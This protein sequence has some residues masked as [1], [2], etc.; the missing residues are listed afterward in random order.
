[1]PNNRALQIIYNM[2]KTK[3]IPKMDEND[4]KRFWSKVIVPENKNECW[5][6]QAS[7]DSCG[8]GRININGSLFSSHRVAY[9]LS[10]GVNPDNQV[11]HHCDNPSCCNQLHLFLGNHSDNMRDRENKG[12]ANHPAGASHFSKTNP[13]KLARG[14][15]TG[16]YTK[17]DCMPKG[18]RMGTAKLT[19]KQALEI[20]ELCRKGNKTY[21]EIAATYNV[22]TT[23]ISGIAKGKG[24]KHLPVGKKATKRVG[25]ADNWTA[26]LTDKKVL[27]IRE[28]YDGKEYTYS[29]LSKK[30]KIGK[31]AIACIITLKTWKHLLPKTG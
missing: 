14:I 29:S 8:Y 31:H 9:F 18:E 11:L 17:P 5:E 23:V 26:K 21:T 22:S 27:K 28:L 16:H 4:L 24:W 7:K 25:G 6:W 19:D 13:E 30:F 1:M 12:R 3:T 15:R 2:S 20:R 10:T